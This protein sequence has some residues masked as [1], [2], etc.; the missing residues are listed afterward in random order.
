MLDCG[1]VDCATADV[2]ATA[3]VGEPDV[4]TLLTTGSETT[5]TAVGLV[6]V[7][8]ELTDTVVTV[9]LVDSV[10]VV[11]VVGVD[12]VVVLFVVGELATVVVGSVVVVAAVVMA[13]VVVVVG[14]T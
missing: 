5:A 10:V 3:V 1:V 7:P 14:V 13:A 6:N 12:D 2:T 8:N 4:K 11:P 9:S